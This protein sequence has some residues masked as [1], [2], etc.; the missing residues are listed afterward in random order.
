[1]HTNL[2]K[3]KVR[4]YRKMDIKRIVRKNK[5]TKNLY[6]KLR[7][8]KHNYLENKKF[9]YTGKF[10]DRK[11]NSEDL[12]IVLAGYKE[13]LYLAVLGRLKQY[14]PENMDICI[15][16]SG[17]WSETLNKICEEN[18]WSYLSTKENNV[19]LV[20]NIAIKYHSKAKY[21]FK[22]DEDIFL[23]EYYFEN[24]KNA[25]K[26]AQK[27]DFEPGVIAPLIPVNGYGHKRILSKLALE[28]V[29]FEKFGEI[30]KH[31]AGHNRFIESNPEVAKFFWGEGNYVPSIDE[32]NDRFSRENKIIKPCPIRFSIGAIMFERS[33]WINMGYFNVDFKGSGLGEDEVQICSYCNLHSRPLMVSENVLVGHL[34]FGPQNKEMNKFFNQN[35]DKFIVK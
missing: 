28:D 21:I 8:E 5:Y 30:S 18:S 19:S 20:Q 13:F 22:I 6:K 31:M 11:K 25:Y 34:S 35:K 26:L 1:M 23:T 27:G 17:V 33:L 10:I 2:S 29:Y 12:C 32:L 16:S 3:I 9:K 7:E 15:I 4:I 14:S 24:L